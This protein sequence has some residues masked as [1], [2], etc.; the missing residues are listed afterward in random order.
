[1]RRALP[2]IA[3]RGTRTSARNATNFHNPICKSGHASRR[4]FLAGL[5]AVGAATILAAQAQLQD[6]GS[7]NAM[8]LIPR[9]KS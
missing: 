8:R 1:M 3:E 9:L 5:G 6:I 7:D 2:V 4:Q